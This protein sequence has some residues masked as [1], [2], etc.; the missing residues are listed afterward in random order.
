MAVEA[1]KVLLY[2]LIT[3]KPV[4]LVETENKIVFIVDPKA[5]KVDIK[6][7]V[8]S[9]YKLK[10]TS[11]RTINTSKGRKKAYIRLSGKGKAAEL[12]TKLKII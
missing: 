11:V 4:G 3:E 9:E 10:V 12:A 6:E 7:A 8:E 5:N 1:E 2:P